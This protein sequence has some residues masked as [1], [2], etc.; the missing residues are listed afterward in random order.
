MK[1]LAIDLCCGKGG[2]TLGLLAAG[3]RVVGFDI[4]NMGYVQHPDAQLVLQDI[5]T[6]DGA[7][8]KEARLIVA[9][10]P[11]QQFSVHGMKMF[12]PNPPYPTLGILLFLHAQRIA[13]EA[14]VPIVLENVRAAQPFVGRSAFHIGAFH[15]WGDVPALMPMVSGRK[16]FKIPLNRDENGKRVYAGDEVY[17]T[18]HGSAARKAWSA[19]IAKIPLPIAQHVG[20]CFLESSAGISLNRGR[21][22]EAEARKGETLL[23]RAMGAADAVLIRL[24]T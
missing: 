13:K 14:K 1:P 16:G 20:E 21:Q 18:S 6:I 12:H 7:T 11:C 17:L 4:E 15:F 8:L 9:S 3:Y 24:E 5:Q 23:G 10:T 22:H 19:E 2:W